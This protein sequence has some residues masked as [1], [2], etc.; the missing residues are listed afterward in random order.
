MIFLEAAAEALRADYSI[1]PHDTCEAV[2]LAAGASY[3]DRA[4][5]IPSNPQPWLDHF[6]MIF[7]TQ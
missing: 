7:R 2:G 1:M 4:A 5:A 6:A 3:A